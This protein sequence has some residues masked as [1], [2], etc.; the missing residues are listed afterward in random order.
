MLAHGLAPLSSPKLMD[1]LSLAGP[2]SIAAPTRD[3]S[4][5]S[6]EAMFL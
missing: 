4:V 3:G 2:G 6:V 1:E 5:N